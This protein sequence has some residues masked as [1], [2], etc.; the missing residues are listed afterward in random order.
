LVDYVRVSP[1]QPLITL[2]RKDWDTLWRQ[3][4]LMEKLGAK[5]YADSFEPDFEPSLAIDDD[6]KTMWHSAWTPEPAKLPHEIVIDLQQAV[7]ISGLRVLP[8]QDGNP[9]GQVAEFEVYVSQDGKS[10]GEAIARG[11]WDA[12]AVERII[13]FPRSITT[14]WIKFVAKRE[15]RGQQFTSLAEIDIIPGE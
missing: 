5:V 15:I 12:R 13:R 8:R 2:S 3:P 1:A 11:T 10:W 7:V 9:N 6:P 4:R 14:Q